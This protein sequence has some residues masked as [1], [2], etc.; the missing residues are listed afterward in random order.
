M[1]HLSRCIPLAL[2]LLS[3][4]Y[5]DGLLNRFQWEFI[6]YFAYKGEEKNY[7]PTPTIDA[8]QRWLRIRCGY[9]VYQTL[10]GWDCLRLSSYDA[11]RRNSRTQ[12]RDSDS[13]V[14]MEDGINGPALDVSA[15]HF[16]Q[17]PVITVGDGTRVQRELGRDGY[18]LIGTK[19]NVDCSKWEDDDIYLP[20]KGK[21]LRKIIMIT[22]KLQLLGAE[23]YTEQFR[24][25][26]GS[27]APRLT[28]A[29]FMEAS[30]GKSGFLC[31]KYWMLIVHKLAVQAVLVFLV[32]II[33]DHCS[34]GI[35]GGTIWGTPSEELLALGCSYLGL[36]VDDYRYYAL[37]CRPN[38]VPETTP[39]QPAAPP[40][41]LPPIFYMPDPRHLWRLVR[42]NLDGL[43]HI[44]FFCVKLGDLEG[45]KVASMGSLHQMSQQRLTTK[46]PLRDIVTINKVM[47][48]KDDAAL[49]L[50]SAA[51]IELLQKHH[52]EVNIG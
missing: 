46:V 20:L 32:A 18:M 33:T 4:Q 44:V 31:F 42:T 24:G 36:P 6:E 14:V 22:R 34:V 27:H 37:Y 48:F 17:S 43:C 40:V 35:S 30:L 49:H 45:S 41:I 25:L 19:K 2:I 47:D 9:Q 52:P 50:V 13:L 39:G 7:K 11:C 10:C 28:Y 5:H 21:D 3:E 12:H 15:A 16:A 38:V 29:T 1:R 8:F 51:C 23:V 26:A